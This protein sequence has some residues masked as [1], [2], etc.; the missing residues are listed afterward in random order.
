LLPTGARPSGGLLG[1]C[2]GR[3]ISPPLSRSKGK[4]GRPIDQ[5]API[6]HDGLEPIGPPAGDLGPVTAC[7][8]GPAP[9]TRAEANLGMAPRAWSP[10]GPAAAGPPRPVRRGTCHVS[11]RPTAGTLAPT[12]PSRRGSASSTR[13]PPAGAARW[14]QADGEVGDFGHDHVS[15]LR[16]RVAARVDGDNIGHQPGELVVVEPDGQHAHPAAATARLNAARRSSR[17]SPALHSRR[18]RTPPPPPRA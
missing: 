9:A 12:A 18:R 16:W 5:A 7:M 3:V 4:R 14:C 10:A 13:T 1:S 15:E 2:P 8:T 11:I 17:S 6:C